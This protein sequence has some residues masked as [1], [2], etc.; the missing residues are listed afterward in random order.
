MTLS[1]KRHEKDLLFTSN[2]GFRSSMLNFFVRFYSFPNCHFLLAMAQFVK[3]PYALDPFAFVATQTFVPSVCVHNTRS[4]NFKIQRSGFVVE[5]GRN[6]YFGDGF[7]K[8]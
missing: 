5:I 4:F 6:S 1:N 8:I 7:E 2:D 3:R